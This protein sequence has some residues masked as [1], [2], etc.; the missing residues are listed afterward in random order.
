MLKSNNGLL[1]VF[2]YFT[3]HMAFYVM[4]DAYEGISVMQGLSFQIRP[5]FFA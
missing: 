5:F 1:N 2:C 3:N 4:N